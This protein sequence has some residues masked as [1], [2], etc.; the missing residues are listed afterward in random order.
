MWYEAGMFACVADGRV[1]RA[2]YSHDLGGDMTKPVW[3][4]N[5]YGFWL[6]ACIYIS[7]TA[8]WLMMHFQ[9]LS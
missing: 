6:A 2:R 1:Q 7:A 9:L 3:H 8:G 4:K 5:S